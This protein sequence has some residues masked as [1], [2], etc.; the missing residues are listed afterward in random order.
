[1]YPTSPAPMVAK[2]PSGRTAETLILVG[3]ILQI[4]FVVIWIIEL[5]TL[6]LRLAAFGAGLFAGFFV[7]IY[8]LFLVL[9]LAVLYLSWT[10]FYNRTKAGNYEGAKSV[11][12]VVVI[13]GFIA[14]GII[15]GILYL[16]AYLKLG[17]AINEQR[18]MGMAGAPMGYPGAPVY[19]APPAYG[20]PAPG[21]G[22]P[23]PGDGSPAPGYGAPPAAASPAPAAGM[24][25]PAAAP[26]APVAPACPRCHN[27][28]TWIPQYNRY[29]CY[30]CQQYV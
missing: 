26:G 24:T 6:S 13:L 15:V 1:M 19:N 5:A 17:D 16:V 25:P 14:G 18:G 9:G 2:P 27:P 7:G 10:H 22:A 8:A 11:G 12:I 20:Q 23:A 29:Y 21:Y 28:A 30:S 4:I 3:L